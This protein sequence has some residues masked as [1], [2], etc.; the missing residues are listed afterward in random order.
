[1]VEE[2]LA[3]ARSRAAALATGDAE[4]LRR[5]MHPDLRWTTYDGRLLDRDAYIAGNTGT[6]LRWRSQTLDDVDVVVTGD[7]AILTALVT[8]VVEHGTFRLRLTQTWVRSPAT[9]WRCL[10]GHA[11][12]APTRR[13]DSPP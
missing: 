12:R 5:L 1:M 4:A 3:A 10:S 6:G 9:G 8:D 11:C 7:T 2:V 13:R